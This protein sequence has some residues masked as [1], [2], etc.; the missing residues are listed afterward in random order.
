M[1]FWFEVGIFVWEGWFAG[2]PTEGDARV[3]A[4]ALGVP[5]PA[6]PATGVDEGIVRIVDGRMFV[7][8]CYRD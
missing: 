1:P 7:E 6:E 2:P 8:N 4:F 3:L 5:P